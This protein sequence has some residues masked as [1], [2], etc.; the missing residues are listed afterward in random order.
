[1][2][3]NKIIGIQV[4]RGISALFILLYHYTSRYNDVDYV[5]PHEDWPFSVPWGCYAVSTFF[6]IS[7]YL[8]ASDITKCYPPIRL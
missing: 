5:T 7:G 3:G 1:M 4:I 2:C 8:T 6:L